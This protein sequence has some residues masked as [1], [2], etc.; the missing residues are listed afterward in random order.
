[1]DNWIKKDGVYSFIINLYDLS[2]KMNNSIKTSQWN[3]NS[4]R[5]TAL[6]C[7][8]LNVC[9]TSITCASD[10]I[11]ITALIKSLWRAFCPTPSHW[12][13]KLPPLHNDS[14][15]LCC[16]LLQAGWYK[17]TGVQRVKGFNSSRDLH[18]SVNSSLKTTRV[19]RRASYHSSQ[20]AEQNSERP[21][22]S[23]VYNTRVC[24]TCARLF[25]ACEY[26][27]GLAPCVDLTLF[28]PPAQNDLFGGPD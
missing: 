20:R 7:T 25:T 24:V 21:R 14:Q 11:L 10:S 22:V 18:Y 3:L 27:V 6:I 13:V 16:P 2:L 19:K 1:M 8:S 17:L 4:W 9:R 28:Y 26:Y 15:H 12:A 5:A 23:R